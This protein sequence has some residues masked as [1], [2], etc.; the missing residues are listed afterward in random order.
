MTAERW[1]TGTSLAWNWPRFLTRKRSRVGAISRLA[2]AGRFRGSRRIQIISL[3]IQ[4]GRCLGLG[5][6]GRPSFLE[7]RL[8]RSPITVVGVGHSILR[9]GNAGR[10]QESAENQN[11]LAHVDSLLL[12]NVSVV[13]A[14]RGA[15][16]I[17]QL[18]CSI[19][20]SRRWCAADKRTEGREP[21]SMTAVVMIR[22]AR[23]RPNSARQ[24]SRPARGKDVGSLRHRRASPLIRSSMSWRPLKRGEPAM[25]GVRT[26]F[27]N[28][29]SSSSLG[30]GSW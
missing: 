30:P 5:R 17:G 23:R 7:R 29:S 10:N 21:G 26:T 1:P 2:A 14:F 24:T 20:P 28:E 8:A 16:G 12:I 18:C 6:C 11:V 13:E 22:A 25:C 15:R 4:A 3:R 9:R 19:H 27:S